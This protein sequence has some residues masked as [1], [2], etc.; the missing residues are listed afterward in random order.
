MG[1]LFLIPQLAL[2]LTDHLLPAKHLF[3][4]RGQLIC[5]SGQRVLH[6]LQGQLVQLQLPRFQLFTLFKKR[7][8]E[9]DTR[10]HIGGG[11]VLPEEA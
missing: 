8:I 11:S 2:Q 5:H 7:L 9:S 3:G 6:A 10:R 1:A 4:G